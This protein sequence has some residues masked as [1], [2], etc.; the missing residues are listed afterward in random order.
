MKF[1]IF[2]LS[3]SSSWGNG[4]AT[5]WRGLCRAMA[6]RSHDVTFF[7]RN[8]PYYS[9]AR[10]L[11]GMEPGK[12]VLYDSLQS[13]LPEVERALAEADVAIVTSYCPDG[14]EATEL[15]LALTRG[16]RIFY[17][18]DTPV[19]LAA[20]DRGQLPGYISPRG[21]GGFDLV[22]SFTGG[23]ALERLQQELGARRVAPLYGHV[24]PLVHH[25]VA[26]EARFSAR[27][28]YLGTYAEDRQAAL[29]E[30][31]FS[32]ARALPQERLLLGG[33]MYPETEAFPNNVVHYPHVPPPEHPAFFCSSQATLSITRSSMAELGYCP[34]GRL[35]EAAACNTPLLSD[36]FEGLDLFFE[37]GSEISIV[38]DMDDVLRALSRSPREQRAQAARARR[39]VL[40]QHTSLRRVEE[41][42]RLLGVPSDRSSVSLRAIPELVPEA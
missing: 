28:S 29:E 36:W 42:E 38:R 4:H 32:P 13:V 25:E 10:D 7:E 17:D 34:S 20:C 9:S 16:T 37:P 6:A 11:F 14:R 19:T 8:T 26:A 1:V 3:I 27:L 33:A 22:L 21:L 18:L 41:L 30:L 12:L 24:D 2:G 23:Q 15:V 5:L 40:D 35:F 31:F 39:R